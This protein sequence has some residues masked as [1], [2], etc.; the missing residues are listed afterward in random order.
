MESQH[1]YSP[2][3]NVEKR[4]KQKIQCSAW[5]HLTSGHA[6]GKNGV[7]CKMQAVAELNHSLHIVV[8][9]H[10]IHQSLNIYSVFIATCDYMSFSCYF[11]R[12]AQIPH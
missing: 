9:I 2:A 11:S 1:S 6:S 12:N 8:P 10:K 5:E 7:L 4:E 3:V